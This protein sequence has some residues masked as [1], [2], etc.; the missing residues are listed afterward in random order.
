VNYDLRPYDGVGP[1]KIGI[2]RVE[3]HGMLGDSP[4]SFLKAGETLTDIYEQFGLF[5]YYDGEAKADAFELFPPANPTFE[6][7]SI[8]GRS[9]REVQDW[10]RKLDPN[11]ETDGAGFTSLHFGVGV[12]APFAMKEPEEPVEAVILFREGYYD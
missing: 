9:F 11:L 4:P 7:E 10:F 6:S 3:V 5:V 2:S 8:L 1:L 12:Y